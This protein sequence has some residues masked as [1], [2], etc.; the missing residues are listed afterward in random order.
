MARRSDNRESKGG[1][2]DSLK[3]AVGKTVTKDWSAGQ[4]GAMRQYGNGSMDYYEKKA[5]LDNEDTRRLEK[6]M[7]D[8]SN[9]KY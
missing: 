6:D 5:R 8:H 3:G 7:L 4:E 1:S 9:D 2:Y